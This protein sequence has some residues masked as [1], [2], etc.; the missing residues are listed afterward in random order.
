MA[1]MNTSL[2]IYDPAMKG[3]Y[4]TWRRGS[5]YF[6]LG[7]IS[8]LIL[9]LIVIVYM[10]RSPSYSSDLAIVL[11][12]TGSSSNFSIEDVGQANQST[13]TPFSGG[14]FSPLANYREIMKSRDVR[15]LAADKLGLDITAIPPLQVKLRQ[16]TSIV[17]VHVV[18]KSPESSQKL[19]WA[20]Y[21]SFQEVLDTLR[22]DEIRRRD[23]RVQSV[24]RNY[25]Q[26][27]DSTRDG[28][29]RFQ[30]RSLLSSSDQVGQL[31]QSIG[32]HKD[33]YIDLL[34]TTK[35]MQDYVRQL[36]LDL[37]ISPAMAGKVFSLQSDAAFR[38]YLK[39][40][41]A[42][43]SLV[44]EYSS[45]WGENHPKVIAQKM[46]Y[47]G[48]RESLKQRSY[49]IIGEWVADGLQTTDLDASPN[50]AE[51]FGELVNQYAK[52][53]GT[54][55][56]INQLDRSLQKMDDRLKVYSREVAELEHLE[57]EHALA[58]AVY[59][60]A[61]AKLEA[62]KSDIF[63]SYPAVQLLSVPSLPLKPKNPNPIIAAAIGGLGF[64]FISFG[65]I[66]LWHRSR[67]MALV[68]KNA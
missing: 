53:K 41:D 23:V 60:S 36:G 4:S 52:L 28:I 27:V 43:A 58:E 25:S 29:I 6:W 57:R 40:L 50:R 63:A 51:L 1:G 30:Q 26:N 47:D 24:L 44:A 12:G 8:Y 61:A 20:I 38:G 5:R 31:I 66:M 7:A 33:R 32:V 42:S 11:P 3:F 59:T 10:M 19:G 18:S 13:R 34:A 46:R 64:I 22:E 14:E 48:A 67:L 35:N 65:L 56:E 49:S 54:Q 16:R 62:S 17:E 37:G 15:E 55:S 68:L 9:V 2:V 39:E 21:D 45:R